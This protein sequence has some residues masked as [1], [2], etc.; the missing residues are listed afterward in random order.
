MFTAHELNITKETSI[1]TIFL[2]C[3]LFSRFVEDSSG[4]FCQMERKVQSHEIN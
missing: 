4:I 2:D 3:I 1:A